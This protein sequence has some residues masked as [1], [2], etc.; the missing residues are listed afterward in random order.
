MNG[1]ASDAP[2]LLG[3]A[4]ATRLRVAERSMSGLV[5]LFGVRRTLPELRHH[6]IYFSGDYRREFAELFDERRFPEG[7][8]GL[9]QRPEPQRPVGRARGGEALFVMANAPAGDDAWDGSRSPAAGGASWR[10]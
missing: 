1:D 4:G 7:P 3:E 8:D 5:F 10:G 9:R 6:T 2:G